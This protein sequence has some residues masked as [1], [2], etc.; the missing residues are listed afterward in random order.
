[1]KITELLKEDFSDDKPNITVQF[2]KSLDVAG[3]YPIIFRDGSRVKVPVADMVT[4]LNHYDELKPF[5]REEIQ[6]VAGHSFDKFK[7]IIRKI[8][9]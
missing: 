4:Y 5:E 9:Q 6:K 3:D 8:Q 7:D 1:M 2:K